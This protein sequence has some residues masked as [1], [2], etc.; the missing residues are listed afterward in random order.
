M[1]LF[2][3]IG[4]LFRRNRIDS[5]IDAE[6]KA[7]IA[8]RT[9]DNIASGMTAEQARRNALVRF[10]NTTSTHEHIA[11]TDVA[12]GLDRF[13]F[14]IRYAWRKLVKSP[15]FT[16]TAAVTIALGIGANTAI[17]SSMDA[18]VLRPLAVP[19]LDRVVVVS[20]QDS[21]GPRQVALGNYEDWKLRTILSR[22]LRFAPAIV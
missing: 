16:A 8:M 20:E 1:A 13:L 11:A 9:D 14:D 10:G 6:L 12:L 19:K 22:I 7:H 18:V 4:N 17:F 5:D 3:R 21:S 15:G 2:R